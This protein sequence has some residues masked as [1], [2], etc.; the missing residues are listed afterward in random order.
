M[1]HKEKELRVEI[2]YVCSL[3]YTVIAE[4]K[5]HPNSQL[6]TLNSIKI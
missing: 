2:Y 5:I 1:G 3:V 4:I 6:S